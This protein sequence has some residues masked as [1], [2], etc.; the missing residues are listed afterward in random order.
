MQVVAEINGQEVCEL[1]LAA[2]TRIKY[3]SYISADGTRLGE[4]L[5][6]TLGQNERLTIMVLPL[7]ASCDVMILAAPPGSDIEDIIQKA[8]IALR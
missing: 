3:S 7:H 8:K 4:S 5:N 2:D 1:V 6:K